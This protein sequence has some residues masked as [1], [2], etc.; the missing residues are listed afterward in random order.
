LNIM[1]KLARREPQPLVRRWRSRMVANVDS[2]GLVV[3]R[4]FE[5]DP[6]CWARNKVD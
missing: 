1:V 2:M 4:C 5:V 6:I 3:L